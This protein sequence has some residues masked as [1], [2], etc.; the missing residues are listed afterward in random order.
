MGYKTVIDFHEYETVEKK[1]RF[2]G[3]LYPVVSEEEVKAILAAIKKEHHQASHHCTAFRLH[4]RQ[5]T[6]RYSDDGEP[7]GTAGMPMLEVLRGQGLEKLVAVSIRYF[8]GTK[9]GTGGL[10]RAYT[11]SV[12]QVIAHGEVV[13]MGTFTKLEVEVAYDL[14]GK[15]EYH[16]NSKGYLTEDVRYGEKVT[17]SL[18]LNSEELEGQTALFT[19]LTNGQCSMKS[20]EPVE[21]YISNGKVIVEDDLYD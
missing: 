4:D 12:Q 2:I 21:G 16:L 11:A 20:Y 13:E 8:G 7:G 6:E 14:A 15:M 10:V 3:R 18:Y 1:S 9:L 19:E 17:Y 5:L